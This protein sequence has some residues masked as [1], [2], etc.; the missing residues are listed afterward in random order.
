ML[1]HFNHCTRTALY[2][3][4]SAGKQQISGLSSSG[5]HHSLLFD[6]GFPN[7]PQ[8]QLHLADGNAAPSDWQQIYFLIFN[9]ISVVK[10]KTF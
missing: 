4:N 6:H 5:S 1:V 10:R 8:L 7:N 9:T 3:A 2:F